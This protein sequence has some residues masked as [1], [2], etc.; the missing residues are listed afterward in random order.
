ML[1]LI[2][3]FKMKISPADAF[4]IIQALGVKEAECLLNFREWELCY[5]LA[6]FAGYPESAVLHFENKMLEARAEEFTPI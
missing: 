5:R 1:D 3:E 4:T 6:L 2:G